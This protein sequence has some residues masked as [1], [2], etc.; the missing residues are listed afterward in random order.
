MRGIVWFLATATPACPTIVRASRGTH[1]FSSKDMCVSMYRACKV[2]GK[3]HPT[4]A[5][6]LRASSRKETCLCLVGTRTS[7][8]YTPS[9]AS[10][11]SNSG[12]TDGT[13]LHMHYM[14]YFWQLC[15][16]ERQGKT[17]HA[18]SSSPSSDGNGIV[19]VAPCNLQVLGIGYSGT[20]GI[21]GG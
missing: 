1:P 18:F 14:D 15:K 17:R 3:E 2:H 21:G 11:R 16:C 10:H 13:N 20:I 5:S 12:S 6:K 7:A 9:L 19:P 8:G 4:K